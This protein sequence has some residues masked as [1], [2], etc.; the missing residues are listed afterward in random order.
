MR[1]YE[2]LYEANKGEQLGYRQDI[3]DKLIDYAN[4]PN[5]YCTLT[6]LPKI[7]V[8]PTPWFIGDNTPVGIYVFELTGQAD[9]LRENY[10]ATLDNGGFITRDH[11]HYINVLTPTNGRQ[12][13]LETYNEFDQ[14]FNTL[15]KSYP[16]SSELLQKLAS[17][18]FVSDGA[19]M[20]W[21]CHDLARELTKDT[22]PPVSANDSWS[23]IDHEGQTK[24][25][26]KGAARE[27]AAQA[28]WNAIMRKTLNW[29][30]IFDPGLGAISKWEKTQGLFL[31][32]ENCKLLER[33]KIPKVHI[34][35]KSPKNP[36][37]KLSHLKSIQDLYKNIINARTLVDL[38]QQ[39]NELRNLLISS[40]YP[41]DVADDLLKKVISS[42][43]ASIARQNQELPTKISQ[44]YKM[45]G[46]KDLGKLPSPRSANQDS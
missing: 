42:R 21:L 26:S 37:A 36:S 29:G 6:T 38:E 23:R 43:E 45:G 41:S 4:K 17:A 40:G 18:H 1:A 15:L 24:E 28:K 12:I 44:Y 20:F 35:Y 8:N 32:V 25:L 3:R 27:I 19:R 13:N 34:N 30:F 31:S 5:M 39:E 46:T 22:Q 10:I 11:A 16:E 33:L 7:G 14:D 9:N 2:F